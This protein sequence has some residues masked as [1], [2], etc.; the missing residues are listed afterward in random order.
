MEILRKRFNSFNENLNTNINNF[1][2]KINPSTSPNSSEIQKVHIPEQNSK[3]EGK[4]NSEIEK[5]WVLVNEVTS[6]I[7]SLGQEIIIN[8][9]SEDIEFKKK[10]IN[11]FLDRFSSPNFTMGNKIGHLFYLLFD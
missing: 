6:S 1:R 11:D 7:A 3:I 9:K 8:P 5:A 4:N 10:Q 2:N